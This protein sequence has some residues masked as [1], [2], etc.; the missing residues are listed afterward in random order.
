MGSYATGRARREAIVSSAAVHF[1]ERGYHK[2]PM[3]R[4]AADVGLTEA[5]LLYHFP[6]KTHLLLAVMDTRLDIELAREGLLPADQ[7]PLRA[8][9]VMLRVLEQLAAKPALMELFM[10]LFGQAADPTSPA[11]GSFSLLYERTI[12]SVSSQL[13][14]AAAAGTVRPDLDFKRIAQQSI[15]VSDGLQFQWIL[16]GGEFDLV[17]RFREYL[18]DLAQQVL[19]EG[20]T[21]EI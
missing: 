18:Q 3:S 4:I 20:V 9:R 21:C 5:G 19:V 14:L 17:A 15:A 7:D 8:F 6:S 2:T 16:M 11:H 13:R 1:L 10:L 12:E